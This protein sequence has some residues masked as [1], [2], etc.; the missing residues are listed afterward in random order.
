[1]SAGGIKCRR[2]T[3]GDVNDGLW[4]FLLWVHILIPVCASTFLV[5]LRNM[6]WLTPMFLCVRLIDE[7]TVTGSWLAG[8]S[9]AANRRRQASRA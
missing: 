9:I 8:T 3:L 4:D 7:E 5:A 2:S 1:M 6:C